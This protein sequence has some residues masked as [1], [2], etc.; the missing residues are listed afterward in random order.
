[1]EARK[2]EAEPVDARNLAAELVFLPTTLAT[3][4]R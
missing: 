3:V 4:T 2:P 1:M